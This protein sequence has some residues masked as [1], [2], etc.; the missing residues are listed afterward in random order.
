MT[1]PD[2]SYIWGLVIGSTI[3]VITDKRV[4]NFFVI[5]KLE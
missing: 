1:K 4:R 5:F 3:E 2:V